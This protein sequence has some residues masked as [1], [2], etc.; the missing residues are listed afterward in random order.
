MA[1]A[2]RKKDSRKDKRS[3]VKL[4]GL[5]GE[6]MRWEALLILMLAAWL[7]GVFVKLMGA[8]LFGLGLTDAMGWIVLAAHSALEA[9]L[10]GLSLRWLRRDL[11]AAALAGV[12]M[13]ILWPLV[14]GLIMVGHVFFSFFLVIP[15]V[16][17][18]FCLVAGIAFGLRLFKVDLPALVI[19]GMF[20][21]G[22]HLIVISLVART[23]ML[24]YLDPYWL[25]AGGLEAG[26][27]GGSWPQFV[28]GGVFGLALWGADRLLP[29]AGDR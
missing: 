6:R 11:R 14:I 1:A 21:K 27:F 13:G 25:Q 22:L 5:D 16:T 10:L 28:A 12:V 3:L 23:G 26:G 24:A 8:V 20:G 2:A 17:A 4:L 9:A 15:Q 29:K 18:T 7:A 19:G